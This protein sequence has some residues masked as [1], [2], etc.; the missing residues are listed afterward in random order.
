MR[1][2]TENRWKRASA[3]LALL[4]WV[5][6]LVFCSAECWLGQCHS[7]V[8]RDHHADAHSTAAHSHGDEKHNHDSPARTPDKSGFCGSL[9]SMLLSAGQ[10]T[11]LPDS[12]LLYVIG[13]P[14]L[15]ASSLPETSESSSDRRAKRPERRFTHE[16]CTASANRSHAPPHFS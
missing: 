14:V 9:D 12:S 1:Q 11:V 7:D 15:F 6:A 10:D 5:G 2:R 8:S 16:V 3:L 4:A 13:S